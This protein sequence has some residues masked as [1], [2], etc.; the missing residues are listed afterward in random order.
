MPDFSHL[1][2]RAA[3]KTAE[4][5]TFPMGLYPGVIS[6][7][8]LEEINRPSISKEKVPALRIRVIPTGW[9]DGIPDDQKVH[10]NPDGVL[11]RV[12]LSKSAFR[13]DFPCPNDLS[14]NSWFYLDEFIRSCGMDPD[15]K[16]YEELFAQLPGQP[17]MLEMQQYLNQQTNR[18]G[19]QLGRVFGRNGA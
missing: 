10:P 13:S 4:P 19:N 18:I 2:K 6:S 1:F 3:G 17:V 11:E 14:H 15:G 7:F 16:D 5:Y 12:D 8:S 9:P